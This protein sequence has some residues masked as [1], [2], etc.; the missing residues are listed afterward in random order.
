MPAPAVQLRSFD[1]N[2]SQSEYVALNR[3]TNRIRLE[4]LPDDP[5]IPLEESI[6]N[7]QSIPTY[8]DLKLWAAWNAEPSEID[9]P[10]K[11]CL[12]AYR[13]KPAPGAI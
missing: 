7:L 1:K 9:R 13:G 4:R 8:V 10:G 6:Q 3:H 11:C 2:A 12:L 5:P